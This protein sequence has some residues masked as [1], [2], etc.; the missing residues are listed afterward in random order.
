MSLHKHWI[1]IDP[2]KDGAVARLN[3]D[4]FVDVWDTPLTDTTDS[5]GKHK[6]VYDGYALAGL[7]RQALGAMKPADVLVVV[8]LVNAGIFGMPGMKMGAVS[9]FSFGEGYGLW[10]GV[11]AGLGCPMLRVSPRKWKAD[12]MDGEPKTKEAVV[13]AASRIYPGAASRLHGPKGGALTGRADA[14]MLA[15]YGRV[16]V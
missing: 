9:A 6:R 8:E 14:I 10:C 3:T 12:L 15:H 16:T 1:G 11:I 5:K 13:P 2:G 7:L 4:G